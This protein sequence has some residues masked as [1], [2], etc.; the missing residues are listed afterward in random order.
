MSFLYVGSQPKTAESDPLLPPPALTEDLLINDLVPA[1]SFSF[2]DARILGMKKETVEDSVRLR[3]ISSLDTDRDE[4]PD[5]EHP[6]F[7]RE[8]GAVFAFSDFA[9]ELENDLDDAICEEINSKRDL[10][11]DV[12]GESEMF[13]FGDFTVGKAKAPEKSVSGDCSELAADMSSEKCLRLSTIAPARRRVQGGIQNHETKLLPGHSARVKCLSISAS[14]QILI[15]TSSKSTMVVALTFYGEEVQR[16]FGHQDIITSSLISNDDKL[17]VTTSRDNTMI[18]W[19][20]A[21]ARQLSLYDHPM[22]VTSCTFSK[23]SHYVVTGCQ[24]WQYVLST[25]FFWLVWVHLVHLLFSR[26]YT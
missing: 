4:E 3:R 9:V 6:D 19:D 15:T 25:I 11:S 20:L 17:L 18:V 16:Y 7:Q 22:V 2:G 8:T 1:E 13:V 21:T 5:T 14:E 12:D 10:S 26:K 24:D 23:N